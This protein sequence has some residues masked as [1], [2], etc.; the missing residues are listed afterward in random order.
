MV[1]QRTRT[2]TSRARPC[3]ASTAARTE[4]HPGSRGHAPGGSSWRA[5]YGQQADNA[6]TFPTA[7]QVRVEPGVHEDKALRTVFLESEGCAKA[8]CKQ[9]VAVARGGF[10]VLRVMIEPANDDDVVDPAGD[11]ELLV[12]HEA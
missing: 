8:G 1:P 3:S 4:C 12:V 10:D 6:K 9:R 7:R 2:T 11:V 5:G